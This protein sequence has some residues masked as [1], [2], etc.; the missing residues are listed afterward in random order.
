MISSPFPLLLLFYALLLVSATDPYQCRSS[1]QVQQFEEL[2][3]NMGL[4]V[5]C[6]AVEKADQAVKNL[7]NGK[8]SGVDSTW[9]Q[10]SRN[11]WNYF[12]LLAIQHYPQVYELPWEKIRRTSELH[13][14]TKYGCVYRWVEGFG[15]HFTTVCIYKR[16]GN[17]TRCFCN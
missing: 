5:D 10:Y 9:C 17:E 13:P 16:L 12:D 3:K 8:P 11:T 4:K 7:M 1:K 2:H 14:G 6:G 15:R